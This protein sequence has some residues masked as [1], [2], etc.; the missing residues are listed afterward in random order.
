MARDLKQL[1]ARVSLLIL[2]S[3]FSLLGA[4]S[5][6]SHAQK[7]WAIGSDIESDCC[8]LGSGI[9]IFAGLIFLATACV[10]WRRRGVASRFAALDARGFAPEAK[11]VEPGLPTKEEF[12]SDGSVLD[13]IPA[14][15]SLTCGS[16]R[17]SEKSRNVSARF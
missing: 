7:S 5:L 3:G 9:S 16:S 13:D 6:I 2:A 17:E 4:L 8:C 11:L 15:R 10:C 14:N 1:Y 12:A